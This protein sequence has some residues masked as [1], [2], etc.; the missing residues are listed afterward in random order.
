MYFW[1]GTNI[2]VPNILWQTK[3]NE[4]FPLYL[5]IWQHPLDIPVFPRPFI[6]QEETAYPKPRLKSDL[7]TKSVKFKKTAQDGITSAYMSV[8]YKCSM[9]LNSFSSLTGLNNHIYRFH[10]DPSTKQHS[11]KQCSKC[12]MT[13]ESLLRHIRMDH[14]GKYCHV[15]TWCNRGFVNK[16]DY[17][18]HIARHTGVTGAFSCITCGKTFNY[19]QQLAKHRR[20]SGH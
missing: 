6:P 18:S 12:Y 7:K 4:K 9:C 13:R 15:C 14:K 17:K 20:L 11:C 3:L 10:E 2:N 19:N 1:G 5:Q 8:S 16:N